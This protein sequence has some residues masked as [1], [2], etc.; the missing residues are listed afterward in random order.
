MDEESKKLKMAIIAGASRAIRYKEIK[1][2]APEQEVIQHVTD[3]AEEILNKIDQE[4]N[5]EL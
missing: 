2:R 4:F 5:E 3:K 1:P